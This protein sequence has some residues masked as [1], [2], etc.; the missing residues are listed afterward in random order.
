MRVLTASFDQ[1]FQLDSV[2][3]AK[4]F[5]RINRRI[6]TLNCRSSLCACNG[7]LQGT[8]ALPSFGS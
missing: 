1:S 8:T 2:K 6:A 7:R 4:N 3:R 5:E